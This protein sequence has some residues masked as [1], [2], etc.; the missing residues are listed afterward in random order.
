MRQRII[1]LFVF[2]LLIFTFS[3][4]SHSHSETGSLS[5]LV[6]KL[7]SSVVNISTTNVIKRKSFGFNSPFQDEQFED[8][9]ERF[10]GENL[11]DREFRNRGLGSGFIISA[12]GYVI[13]NNH[14]IQKADEIEVVLQ[15]GEKLE[16]EVIGADH[17]T[18]IAL[19]K[20]KPK[21][22]L[23]A[24][25]LGNSS[26]LEIGDTVLAIG[27]PFGLGHTVTTGIV[28][29]KGRSLG[30]GAY[31]DFIQT[32]AAINP[33]NSGGPLFNLKGEVVG[34]NTA[35]IAGGQGI[36]FSIP[37]NLANSIVSQLRADGKVV[38]GWL[39]V[40]VQ[41]LSPEISKGLGLNTT[42]GALVSDIAP[43]GPAD[44]AGIKRGDIIREVN[45]K[46]IID[47]PELP[48]TIATYK[49]DTFATLK[50]IRDG[51][52]QIMKVKLGELPEEGDVAA[53]NEVEEEVKQ[54]KLGLVVTDITPQ[55]MR[56]LRLSSSEGVVVADIVAGSTASEAGFRV[57]DVI[58]EI[59]KENITSVNDYKKVVSNIKDKENLLFLVK[60]ANRTVYLALKV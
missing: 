40:I 54:D 33:G 4:D 5:G 11:P 43:G 16:A 36:S 10:F 22:P 55:I 18:D 37:I 51:K 46:K 52:E 32:D 56:R 60:R 15:D 34:V 38:R 9:F 12:D 1:S 48:K 2:F 8:L 29:A 47:M 53:K 26:I 28:S 58:L 39:G 50:V 30:L 23:P 44:K 7:S 41:E 35:I 19:L 14:V 13:T 6:K 20:V 17:K 27:N 57:G 31:D 42:D 21:K 3:T 49:P 45:G 25:K 24:V 59:E